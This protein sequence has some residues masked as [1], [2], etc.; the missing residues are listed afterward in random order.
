MGTFCKW[1]LKSTCSSDVCSEFDTWRKGKMKQS[2]NA[3]LHRLLVKWTS[4]HHVID[5]ISWPQTEHL[6]ACFPFEYSFKNGQSWIWLTSLYLE[7]NWIPPAWLILVLLF[8]VCFFFFAVAGDLLSLCG[9]SAGSEIAEIEAEPQQG[10]LLSLQFWD[11]IQGCPLMSL[12]PLPFGFVVC[13]WGEEPVAM[14]GLALHS[15]WWLGQDEIPTHYECKMI[16]WD[17]QEIHETYMTWIAEIVR[18]K[19]AL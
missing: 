11:K 8:P 17:R 15:L 3:T 16:T 1:N 10:G 14:E 12:Q 18:W 5:R 19:T 13:S 2:G 9:F 7:T 6:H 4:C